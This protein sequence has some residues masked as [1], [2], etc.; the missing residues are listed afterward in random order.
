M[1]RGRLPSSKGLRCA[2]L[3]RPAR[4]GIRPCGARQY[5]DTDP[6]DPF[7][8]PPTVR[9]GIGF[10]SA[11]QASGDRGPGPLWRRPGIRNAPPPGSGD[12]LRSDSEPQI[13]PAWPSAGRHGPTS[14]FPL[15]EEKWGC[16]P[17]VK[18]ERRAGRRRCSRRRLSVTIPYRRTVTERRTQMFL[19]S[20]S[21]S[22]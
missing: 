15:H 5:V 8:Y 18:R 4:S 1:D 19:L 9:S 21:L 10:R 12:S 13:L 2:R 6:I 7:K 16:R 3:E 14:S 17:A 20:S 11:R 22:T